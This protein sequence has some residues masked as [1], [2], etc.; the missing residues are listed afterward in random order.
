[1]AVMLGRGSDRVRQ[2]RVQKPICESRSSRATDDVEKAA[3]TPSIRIAFFSCRRDGIDGPLVQRRGLW[4]SYWG[5]S[6]S[7]YNGP[8]FQLWELETPIR[9]RAAPLRS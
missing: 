6:A 7:G 3:Q 2:G 9:I 4:G 1:M 5:P 8:S